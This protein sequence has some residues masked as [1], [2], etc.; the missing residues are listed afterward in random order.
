MVD[1]RGIWTC[2]AGAIPTSTATLA[3]ASSG[4]T[5]RYD[6]RDCIV[7]DYISEMIGD[8]T[9]GA[10]L[11]SSTTYNAGYTITRDA[12]TGRITIAA[13]DAELGESISVTR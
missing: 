4:V 10:N 6:I 2:A 8:P 3:G 7:P 1:N 11:T 13:P 12:T 5:P 9:S